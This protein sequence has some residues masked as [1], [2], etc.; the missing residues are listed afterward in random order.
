MDKAMLTELQRK[1]RQL[2]TVE[3]ATKAAQ[4]MN[5]VGYVECSALTQRGMKTVFDTAISA[6]IGTLQKGGKKKT[7]KNSDKCSIL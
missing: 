3:Q 2:V 4:E 5:A 7:K 6:A 1:N